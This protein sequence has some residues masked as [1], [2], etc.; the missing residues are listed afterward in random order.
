MELLIQ[1]KSTNVKEIVLKILYLCYSTEEKH[2]D[3][4]Q[5]EIL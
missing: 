2:I 5:K 1:V 3:Q 4:K